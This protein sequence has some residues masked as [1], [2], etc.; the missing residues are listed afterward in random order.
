LNCYE[1]LGV[2]IKLKTTPFE[3]NVLNIALYEFPP[4]K[5]TITLAT[6]KSAI[7]KVII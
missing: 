4:R 5:Y 2:R 6:C 7:I 1:V 3:N